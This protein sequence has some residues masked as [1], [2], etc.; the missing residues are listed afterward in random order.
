MFID[1]VIPSNVASS[2]VFPSDIAF[3]LFTLSISR[4]SEEDFS[5]KLTLFL[6]NPITSITS[7]VIGIYVPAYILDEP[8]MS[9]IS[10]T[11]G[12]F[13]LTLNVLLILLPVLS[14]HIATTS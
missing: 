1:P 3:I 13:T 6:L 8:I 5:E 12:Y 10:L 11:F 4:I 14:K 2:V 7:Y 9:F